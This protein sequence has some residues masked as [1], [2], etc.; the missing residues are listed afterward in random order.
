MYK[1]MRLY[2]LFIS[3]FIS[4]IAFSQ[5]PQEKAPKPLN[6]IMHVADSCFNISNFYGAHQAYK[7]A[8]YF[9]PKKYDPAVAYKCAESCRL[10]QN[11]AEAENFYKFTIS[12][13]STGYP[14]AYYWYAEMLKFQ[15][16]YKA[17]AEAFDEFLSFKKGS[18]YQKQKAKHEIV[19]C[20]DSIGNVTTDEDITLTRIPEASI[21]S[22]YSE[23]S[24]CQYQDTVLFFSGIRPY[25]KKAADTAYDFKNYFTKVYQSMYYDSAWHVAKEVE[26]V[27][28]ENTHTGNL[29]FSPD[30]TEVF[31]SRCELKEKYY[32]NIY[33]GDF[34][35]GKVRNADILAE[36]LNKK[37]YNT[38]NPSLIQTPEGQY[39]FFSSDRP[40]GS[41]KKDIWYAKRKVDGSFEQP[42]NCGKS[43]NTFGDEVTP[44]Y[45]NRD[46]LLFFSS[47]THASIGG[48]DVFSSK[49]NLTENKW[50]YA[51]NVG[52]PINSSY[53]D[54][55]FHYSSDSTTAYLVSNRTESTKL[56]D[57][58][59]SNDIYTFKLVRRSIERISELVP[60]Q[61]YFDND[62]PNPGTLDTTSEEIYEDL[63]L[64]YMDRR[65]EY[66][67]QSTKG[68]SN[69]VQQYY[70]RVI[71]ELFD[72]NI[73]K[74]WVKLF[75][76][77]E[78]MEVILD[79]GYD[80][81]IT[82]KGYSSPLG[83]TVY[84]ERIAK[85]RI[86]CVQ[87]FFDSFKDGV[88]N[89]Y[90][91]NEPET[92]QGSLRYMQVALGE[93]VAENTFM[94]KGGEVLNADDLESR[95]NIKKSI[96]SPAAALQR[97]IEILAVEIEEKAKLEEEL[98][99]EIE[100]TK[101]EISEEEAIKYGLKDTTTHVKVDSIIIDTLTVDSLNT[102]NTEVDT[103]DL[104]IESTDDIIEEEVQTEDEIINDNTSEGLK[105]EDEVIEEE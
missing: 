16:K 101:K 98:Q 67:K 19:I 59:H 62:Q 1:P 4:T 13:D 80:I 82:F 58:A 74:G 43:V 26:G 6:V 75:L 92:G 60:L 42:K 46:S 85:R 7:E 68:M 102:D 78:L 48:F 24:P 34:K 66:K 83:N 35:N 56:I 12:I 22:R 39:M 96:Y 77:A 28:A 94:K 64:A 81:I 18:D 45:D 86:A 89:Q 50:D 105:N 9:N 2:L 40:G 70:E 38:T 93:T 87:N 21:N 33:R 37:G 103:E 36:P 53:N 32:C 84:N 63:F 72:N 29:T 71:D 23:Y 15:G 41:G 31:F 95:K 104:N 8:L 10:Y 69:D 52:Y 44:Y 25:D 5:I 47:E 3:I 27:N 54:M 65:D 88:F 14:E 49:G 79:D 11:Y 90:V 51:K 76:F 20:M 57:Q 100:N 30:F 73:E 99:S 17:A 97:K 61:L 55:Y 91:G